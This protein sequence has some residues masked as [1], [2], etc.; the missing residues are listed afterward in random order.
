MVY[1]G[2]SGID[3]GG[4][5]RKKRIYPAALDYQSDALTLENSQPPFILWVVYI[6]LVVVII[7]FIGWACVFKVDRVVTAHGKLVTERPNI[8]L[9]PLERIVVKEVNV[10]VGQIVKK[11]QLL[12]TFDPTFS[13]ADSERLQLLQDSYNC[14]AERLRAELHGQKFADIPAV[15][16]NRNFVR[17]QVIFNERQRFFGEKIV[18]YDENIKRLESIL[19]TRKLNCE[20]Q[21][22]RMDALIKLES[23]YQDLHKKHATSLKDLL[24]LKIQR[25]EFEGSLDTLEGQ[26]TESE[27]ELLSARSE[28]NSFLNQWK[29]DIAKE[30]VE[31]E[32]EIESVTQQLNKAQRSISLTELRAPCDAVIHEIAAYQEGS[33]VRE[34]EALITL[35]PIDVAIEAQVNVDPRN[36][37]KI[38]PADKAKIKLEAFPFQRYG[39]LSGCVRTISEDTMQQQSADGLRQQSYYQVK[40]TL[41]GKLSDRA[42]NYRLIPGMQVT[43]EIKV[44]E[45]RVIEYLIDPLIKALDESLNEP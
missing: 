15:A 9:K 20:K 24:E 13:H 14:H 5:M 36:I 33:A 28:K 3:R 29:E 19:A 32:R 38:K 40:L 44:G 21:R 42:K 11:N 25:I 16:E 12:I 27:H 43:A 4:I 35:V 34:A 10:K 39:T 23:M 31:V 8:V 37:G 6:I 17:Q 22:E 26:V 41:S 18:F 2:I 30:L 7:T 1:T 45:R